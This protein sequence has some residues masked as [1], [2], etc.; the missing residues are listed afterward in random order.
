L[1]HVSE[2]IDHDDDLARMPDRRAGPV[3]RR[4]RSARLL[5]SDHHHAAFVAPPAVPHPPPPLPLPKMSRRPKSARSRSDCALQDNA[6]IG[7]ATNPHGA[8]GGG[9]RVRGYVPRLTT[10]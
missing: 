6:D 8:R 9:K 4:A 10:C 5:A 3:I 7:I 2:D 1:R